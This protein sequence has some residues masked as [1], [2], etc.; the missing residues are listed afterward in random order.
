MAKGESGPMLET[1]SVWSR[2]L[3]A[4]LKR[5]GREM[6]AAALPNAVQE[7][8]AASHHWLHLQHPERVVARMMDFF[9]SNQLR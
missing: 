9:D 3:D 2:D 1:A 4:V 6:L 7:E 8:F 5:R